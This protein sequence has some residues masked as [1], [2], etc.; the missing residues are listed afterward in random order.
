MKKSILTFTL[1]FGMVISFTTSCNKEETREEE[2]EN[3]YTIPAVSTSA[4]SDITSTN[5]NSGGNVSLDGGSPVTAKGVCWNTSPNPTKENNLT[6]DGTGV[7]NFSSNIEG[8][9]PSTTYYLRAYATNAVGTAYGNEISFTTINEDTQVTPQFE[10]FK[11]IDGKEIRNI[12]KTTDGGYIAFAFAEDYDVIKFDADFNI[13]WNKTYGG[14]KQDYAESISQ[15]SDGGYLVLGYSKSNDG[16]VTVNHGEADIWACKIDQA[17]NLVWE[18]SYGGSAFDG[19]GK[20]KSVLLT[21]DGGFIFTA[22]TKSNDGDVSLNKGEYDIWL[23]KAN[24]TGEIQFEKTFGGSENDFGRQIIKTNS[25]FTI[26]VSTRSGNGDFN[27]PGNWIIQ[28]DKNGNE[29]W[30]TNFNVLNSGA[31]NNTSD[32][33]IVVV[34]NSA[35]QYFLNKLDFNGN[36]IMSNIIDFQS[37]SSKQPS[38]VHIHETSDQGFVIIGDLGNGNDSDALLF[39]VSPAL[40]LVYNKIYSG[41]D[42]DMSASFIPL[43]TNN[44]IY[45]FS[46]YSHDIPNLPYSSAEASVIVMLEEIID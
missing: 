23:V 8:L 7:G 13:Q 1:V 17:G 20:E 30:K 4:I 15:T 12:I 10:I 37:I 46:T 6:L 18:K 22:Y 36:V 21:D 16:D 43:N 32:N 44:Y 38:S 3:N 25:N 14:T 27:A 28:I 2:I 9:T 31:I 26:S 19:I 35:T 11:I 39:R 34:N 24:S 33:G 41:S 5:A 40:N 29:I 45:Q 42:L